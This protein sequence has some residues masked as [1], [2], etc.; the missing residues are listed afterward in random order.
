MLPGGMAVS[1]RLRGYEFEAGWSGLHRG[2]EAY[3]PTD[4]KLATTA[5]RKR[6]HLANK[7]GEVSGVIG[8]SCC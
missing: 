5:R 7:V 4:K 6:S 3:V 2:G 1:I 8:L